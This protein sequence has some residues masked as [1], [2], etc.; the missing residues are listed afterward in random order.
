MYKNMDVM[1]ELQVLVELMVGQSLVNTRENERREAGKKAW[2][3]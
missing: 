1:D 3:R 2:S